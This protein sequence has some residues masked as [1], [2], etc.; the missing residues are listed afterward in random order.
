M[1]VKDLYFLYS[2]TVLPD[3][4]TAVRSQGVIGY[5][6]QH[7]LAICWFKR[8]SPFFFFFCSVLHPELILFIPSIFWNVSINK[9]VNKKIF[10]I[11]RK[12]Q[13]QICGRRLQD[14][15]F[16]PQYWKEIFRRP[17]VCSLH[18][19]ARYGG[20]TWNANTGRPRKQGC[21]DFEASSVYIR[22]FT[23]T[24]TDCRVRPYL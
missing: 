3:S 10:S 20:S 12:H 14:S 19:S 6:S 24:W 1:F 22:S 4:E 16:A 21:Q 2:I 5:M 17:K 9:I 13:G 15:T 8:C 7:Y 18:R 11:L 23:T